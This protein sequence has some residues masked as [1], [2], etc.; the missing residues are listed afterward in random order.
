MRQHWCF[1]RLTLLKESC[2]GNKSYSQISTSDCSIGDRV[3]NDVN[4]NGIQ[5]A[6]EPGIPGVT[7]QLVQNG[8]VV[9]TAVTGNDG[10]YSFP[11][12]ACGTYTVVFGL[13][14]GFE[15]TAPNQGSDNTLNS[16]VTNFA[17]GSTDAFTLQPGQRVTNIDA[18]VKRSM[19]QGQNL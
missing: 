19:L 18:G 8:I 6:G 9:A 2:W 17:T 4:G 3:W 12:V 5:D 16:K 10:I 15:F 7:V 11:S 1:K 14:A 13:P